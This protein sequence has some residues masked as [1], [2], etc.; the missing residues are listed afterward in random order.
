MRHVT[1]TNQSSVFLDHVASSTN[2]R[3][4]L[5]LSWYLIS[6]TSSLDIGDT[7]SVRY[8]PKPGEIV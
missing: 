5:T 6:M 7:C 3:R 1:S 2:E 8:G 4:G